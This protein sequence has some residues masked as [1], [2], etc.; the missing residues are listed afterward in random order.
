MVFLFPQA[1]I[2]LKNAEISMSCLLVYLCGILIGSNEMNDL[3]LTSAAAKSKRDLTFSGSE[4][5]MSEIDRILVKRT[6]DFYDFISFD[7]IFFFDIIEVFD[8]NTT[9]QTCFDF[10]DIILEAF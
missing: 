8:G 4:A 6:F 5:N 10:F 3:L 9:F 2:A 1:R 7:T